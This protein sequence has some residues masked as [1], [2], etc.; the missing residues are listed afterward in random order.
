MM[1]LAIGS[2]GY[3]IVLYNIVTESKHEVAQNS[4]NWLIKCTL[5]YSEISL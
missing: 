4:V 1:G 5:K 3:G 2:V